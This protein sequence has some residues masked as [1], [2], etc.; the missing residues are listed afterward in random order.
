MP[1]ID[2][3]PLLP[4]GVSAAGKSSLI[5][6]MKRVGGTGSV[7][8][9]TI[10]PVP[11][12]TLGLLRV[13]GV[14]L[15]P[16]RRVFDTPGV[17]HPYQLTSRINLEELGMVLPRKQLKPRTYRLGEGYSIQIGG[18]GQIDVVKTP[19]A[20]IYLTLYISD[21]IVTHMGKT[22]GAAERRE[23][24]GGVMLVPPTS[25]E[26]MEE[27]G[28]LQPRDCQVVGVS[29]SEHTKD[30]AIAGEGNGGR[31]WGGGGPYGWGGGASETGGGGT[32][33]VF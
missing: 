6:A 30:I 14:P 23:K 3:C 2:V 19:A 31:V 21:S 20:T 32:M 1:V 26:R 9:P 11:G 33:R 29:W 5:S 18:I 12:T 8:P 10:A 25:P 4:L 13:P 24:H 7:A 27:L 15:G 28:P 16:K 17:H 22:S